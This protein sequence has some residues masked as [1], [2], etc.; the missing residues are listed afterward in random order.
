[1][2]ATTTLSA[3]LLALAL[4]LNAC[5]GE[6][7]PANEA[8]AESTMETAAETSAAIFKPDPAAQVDSVAGFRKLLD[9]AGVTGNILVYDSRDGQYYSNDF[10]RCA[11][12]WLPAS[13]FKIVNTMIGLETGELKNK[14]DLFAWDSIPRRMDA[15]N[16]DLR[17][18]EAYQVS[19]VPC[20]QQLARR[21]GP[22]R[23]NA[24]LDSI[25][26]P[27]MDV[28]SETIDTFWLEGESRISSLQQLD[29]VHR[30]LKQE[31]PLSDHTYKQ[32]REIMLL[33][34]SNGLRLS[35]KTGWSIR[36]EFNIGW[37]V[38]M[39]EGPDSYA[40]VVVNIEP[41]ERIEPDNFPMVRQKLAMQALRQMGYDL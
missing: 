10:N 37:F 16:R 12:S 33:G 24:W 9:S 18:I 5:G 38:G 2:R 1:M 41:T 39:V 22:E 28:N 29:F 13:T 36:D 27:G 31:L 32:L 35:G 4:N 30:L 20:Y 3:L 19:C 25:D 15:W 23:M 7:Q 40:C 6:E 34:E 17:L 14:H 8:S 21:I 11:K 26:Y